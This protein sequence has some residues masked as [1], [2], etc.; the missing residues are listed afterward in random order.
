MESKLNVE[1]ETIFEQSGTARQK[2]FFVKTVTVVDLRHHDRN[3]KDQTQSPTDYGVISTV[4]QALFLKR[5]GIIPRFVLISPQPRAMRT[6]E[7][8]ES[9]LRT[10]LIPLVFPSLNDLRNLPSFPVA[11]LISESE[12]AGI[13]L[14]EYAISTEWTRE[15]LFERAVRFNSSFAEWVNRNVNDGDTILMISHAGAI[16]MRCLQMMLAQSGGDFVF[17]QELA[18]LNLADLPGGIFATSEGV[19]YHDVVI[20]NDRNIVTCSAIKQLRLPPEITALRK[21]FP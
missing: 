20:E 12:A 21:I 10:G 3:R 9:A 7:L 15:A 17:D 13:S 6:W 14:E 18:D 2:E 5:A 8:I 11:R 4:A 16:V 1:K 19:I